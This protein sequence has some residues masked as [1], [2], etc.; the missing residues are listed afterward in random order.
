[1]VALLLSA[2]YAHADQWLTTRNAKRGDRILGQLK[3]HFFITC[4]NDRIN[5]SGIP[6]AVVVDAQVSCPKASINDAQEEQ[7]EL[8]REREIVE[9]LRR[10]N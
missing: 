8:E 6:D 4:H 10:S 2:P 3:G 9:R 1:V 5:I 7:E